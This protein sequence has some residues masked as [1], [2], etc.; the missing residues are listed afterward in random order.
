MG[1]IRLTHAL[2]VQAC[3]IDDSVLRIDGCQ[4]GGLCRIIFQGTYASDFCGIIRSA[5]GGTFISPPCRM[6][7]STVPV[8]VQASLITLHLNSG[9]ARHRVHSEPIIGTLVNCRQVPLDFI[10]VDCSVTVLVPVSRQTLI[11]AISCLKRSAVKCNLVSCRHYISDR[12]G[13]VHVS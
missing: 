3:N 13:C 1:S 5:I 4:F 12:G 10:A 8:I 11:Y 9:L 7:R 6:L 2:F